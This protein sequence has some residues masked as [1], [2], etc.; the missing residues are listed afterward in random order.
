MLREWRQVRLQSGILAADFV[1]TPAFVSTTTRQLG[2][3]TRRDEDSIL[4][5]VFSS[6]CGD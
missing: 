6:W 5:S 1:A 2:A 4:P 3:T